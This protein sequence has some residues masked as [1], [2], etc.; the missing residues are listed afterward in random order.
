MEILTGE[1][2]RSSKIMHISNI[3]EQNSPVSCNTRFSTRGRAAC[4]DFRSFLHAALTCFSSGF[5]MPLSL[6]Y[7]RRVS[8]QFEA[9]GE[10]ILGRLLGPIKTILLTAAVMQGSG[11]S[12]NFGVSLG[13][14][15]FL[16]NSFKAIY[17]L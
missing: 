9:P 1:L 2:I 11:C 16:P 12:S 13:S 8:R 5:V 17:E 4:T 10:Y 7:A 6:Q 14:L 3:L 15:D